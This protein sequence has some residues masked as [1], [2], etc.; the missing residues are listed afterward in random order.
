[1]AK[2]ECAQ[3]IIGRFKAKEFKASEFEIMSESGP[4][5]PNTGTRERV[6]R[7]NLYNE[8]VRKI[9]D[10]TPHDLTVRCAN[11]LRNTQR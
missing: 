11:P 9:A 4:E 3:V 5:T 6:E 1:M 2:Q 10:K 8:S 7:E